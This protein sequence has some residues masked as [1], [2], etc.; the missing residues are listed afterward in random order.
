MNPFPYEGPPSTDDR[1][2]AG[3]RVLVRLGRQ[4]VTYNEA[5]AALLGLVGL[6]LGEQ[7][8]GIKTVL[9]EP[10]WFVGAFVASYLIGRR[11]RG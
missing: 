1:L 6:P 2:L 10:W 5:H 8:V 4:D 11:F 9:K 7:G 3:N